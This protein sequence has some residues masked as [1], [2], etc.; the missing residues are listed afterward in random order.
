MRNFT[1]NKLLTSKYIIIRQEIF[2]TNEFS[3][4]KGKAT[5]FALCFNLK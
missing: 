4:W 1:S 3:D 2:K 5:A